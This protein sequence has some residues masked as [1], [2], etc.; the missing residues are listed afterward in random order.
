MFGMPTAPVLPYSEADLE[1]LA[2]EV[3]QSQTAVTGVQAKMSLHISENNKDADQ[4]F[5][6][7]GLWGGYI[8]KPPST[9][10]PQMPEVEDLSMHLAA[11][12][13]IK[14]APTASFAWLPATWLTSP[15]ASTEPKRE[16]WQ[17]KTCVN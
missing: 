16:N 12:A 17:W 8:L 10:Y 6:I 15:N 4:R 5:T 13:K 14:T 2:R 3:I 11:I 1:P 7:V 9:M